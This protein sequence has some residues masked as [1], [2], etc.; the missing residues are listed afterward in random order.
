MLMKRTILKNYS[1]ITTLINYFIKNLWITSR[2][3]QKIK[4]NNIKSDIL[5]EKGK[6][7]FLFMIKNNFLRCLLNEIFLFND[8]VSI[9]IFFYIKFIHQE[10]EKNIAW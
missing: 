10:S 7:L 8:I 9:Y 6:L 3:I 5:I 4:S 1:N 2:I